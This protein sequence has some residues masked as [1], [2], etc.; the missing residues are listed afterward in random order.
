MAFL[1]GMHD[2]SVRMKS[3]TSPR[4]TATSALLAEGYTE[5]GQLSPFDSIRRQSQYSLASTLGARL[6]I[7]SGAN[8]DDNHVIDEML[9]RIGSHR[10]SVRVDRPNIPPRKPDSWL[11]K[12][13]VD[14][15]FCNNYF[16]LQPQY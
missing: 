14:V 2:G 5:D 1:A 8:L 4:S 13:F 10:G 9:H 12:V 11:G 6:S 15:C 3:H 7:A 16:I